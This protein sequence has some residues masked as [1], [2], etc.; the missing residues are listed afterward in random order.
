MTESAIKVAEMPDAPNAL[1][2]AYVALARLTATVRKT[3]TLDA[4]PGP[5]LLE[6]DD[7]IFD[8]L[9]D[10]KRAKLEAAGIRTLPPIDANWNVGGF[11]L[12]RRLRPLAA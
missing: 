5:L 11:T 2:I 1:A 6:L 12:R 4:S 9:V 3:D 8:A 7:D 10:P